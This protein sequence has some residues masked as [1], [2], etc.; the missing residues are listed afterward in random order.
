LVSQ[1]PHGVGGYDIW[2][3]TGVMAAIPT[4]VGVRDQ[5]VSLQIST[6]GKFSNEILLNFW[7]T[8]EKKLLGQ[9]EVNFN[10]SDEADYDVCNG[11]VVGDDV[12]VFGICGA[13]SFVGIFPTTFTA[14]HWTCSGGSA[15][16]DSFSLKF[17]LLNDWELEGPICSMYRR[18]LILCS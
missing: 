12:N 2:A 3:P 11:K 15:G 1:P 5:V 14:T 8:K 18:V 10:C 6:K 16:V 4:I 17:S 9:S 7:A 13:P